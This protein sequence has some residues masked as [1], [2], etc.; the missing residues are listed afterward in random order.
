M[1]YELTVENTPDGRR[2]IVSRYI[3]A[4]PE[5]VW[6]LFVDTDMWPVWGPS[7]T[8]V[9]T[10]ER[11]IDTGATGQVRVRGGIW[12]PFTVTVVSDFRWTWRIGPVSA[13][14][15]RV[16]PADGGCRAA[17]EV[18]LLAVPYIPVCV[19]GLGALSSLAAQR[20]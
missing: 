14:G 11:H 12:L 4:P 13:T 9:S 6:E 17:F 8:E 1:D 7:I 19:L 16:E 15:H 3:D 5:E 10:S 2:W 18:P 20:T